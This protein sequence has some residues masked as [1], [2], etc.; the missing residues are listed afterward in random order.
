[1]N[2]YLLRHAD[3]QAVAPSDAER[4]LSPKGQD[5][6][7]QMGIFLDHKKIEMDVILTSPYL[8]ARQTAE[9]VAREVGVPVVTASFLASGMTPHDGMEGLKE[10]MKFKSVLVVGHQ[11]DLGDLIATLLGIPGSVV[12]IKKGSL[13]ML[14]VDAL[15]PG[16][17]QLEALMPAEFA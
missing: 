10:Y 1:M 2:L 14:S 12:M 15:R 17:S 9:A 13:A 11:P 16:F 3:A 4:P 8:R 7:F 5:Q 6:A